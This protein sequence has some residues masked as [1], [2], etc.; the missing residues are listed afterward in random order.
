MD[1]SSRSRL[2]LLSMKACGTSTVGG[3]FLLELASM[4]RRYPAEMRAASANR[5]IQTFFGDL[6]GA[7]GPTRTDT[8]VRNSILSRA[9]LPFRHRGPDAL[10]IG[11]V[12]T[13]QLRGA[14]RR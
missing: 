14:C 2:A 6:A 10:A 11:G 7:P 1:A 8:A 5:K 13:N 12:V 4:D 9:R 3:A